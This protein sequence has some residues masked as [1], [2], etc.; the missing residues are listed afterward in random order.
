MQRY[1]P[2]H[3]PAPKG[4]H[5]L[6]ATC[7]YNTLMQCILSLPSLYDALERAKST[8]PLLAMWRDALA[9]REIGPAAESIWRD[10]IKRSSE[11]K[12]RVRMDNGQ[13]DA[14]EGLMLLLES[15]EGIPGVENLFRHHHQVFIH[16]GACSKY[17]VN[18]I[19]KG[20]TFEVQ[21]DLKNSQI[22][23]FKALDEFYG[24]E[25]P[26]NDF[27]R[28]QNSYVDADHKCPNCG[29]R[30]EKYK[31]TQLTMVPEILIIAIKKYEKKVV[32]EFPSK[33]EFPA[34]GGRTKLVY[35]LVAQAE[36]S[37]GQGGGHYWALA[38]RRGAWHT[39]NDS[40]ISAGTGGPTMNTYLVFY[41]YMGE[42]PV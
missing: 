16:C 21:P 2:A 15:L 41:H 4:L 33:L 1:N 27:L 29:S 42:V 19:E 39:L 14:H 7:Y 11:K 6:G 35:E 40:S 8:H 22:E 20:F 28:Q 9:G 32:T 37:G 34:I 31:V 36:H 12:D 25:V 13:Q 38:Q 5:N 3:S 23:K 18:K 17:V 10:L 30:G 24:R 26:L